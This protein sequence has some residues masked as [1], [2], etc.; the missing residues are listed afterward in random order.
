MQKRNNVLQNLKNQKVLNLKEWKTIPT[1]FVTDESKE[2]V[3]LIKKRDVECKNKKVE[4][5]L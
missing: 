2:N 5:F 4:V 1:I 3:S